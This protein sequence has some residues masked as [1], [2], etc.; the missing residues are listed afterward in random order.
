MKFLILF[1]LFLLIIPSPSKAGFLSLY[2]AVQ[3][4]DA[5]NK[6]QQAQQ[7]SVDMAEKISQLQNQV[8]NLTLAVQ[9]LVYN[10]LTPAERAKA[11]K[12]TAAEKAKHEYQ[13]T[14]VKEAIAEAKKAR[15]VAAIQAAR[16]KKLAEAT[17]R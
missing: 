16:E 12:K 4:S 10:S 13:L 11:D 2:A 8:N 5:A 15:E 9:A 14:H 6:A 1:G 17:R 7:A 3:A